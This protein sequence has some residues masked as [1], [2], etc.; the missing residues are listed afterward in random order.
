MN[1]FA[2]AVLASRKL[3]ELSNRSERYSKQT[4]AYSRTLIHLSEAALLK[5]VRSSG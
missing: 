3:I 1:S 4:V 2:K 5:E